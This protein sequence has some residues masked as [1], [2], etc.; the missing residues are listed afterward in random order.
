MGVQLVD[1]SSPNMSFT[2]A[3]KNSHTNLCV[4]FVLLSM[5]GLEL[6]SSSHGTQKSSSIIS[7]PYT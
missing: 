3:P 5:D 7:K 4:T 6:T 1:L 2:N